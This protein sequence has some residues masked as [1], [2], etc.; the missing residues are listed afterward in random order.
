MAQN[1]MDQIVR[2]TPV[3]PQKESSVN[4]GKRKWDENKGK[5]SNQHPSKRQETPRNNND[6]S[7][8]NPNYRGKQPHCKRCGK[9]HQGYC[10]V[11]CDK[12]KKTGHMVKDYRVKLPGAP[13]SCY[14]CGQTGHFKNNC[15]NKKNDGPA[16]GRTFNINTREAHEDPD[17]VTGMSLLNNHFVSVLFDTG[18]D[19]SFISKEFRHD[20]SK[21]L[22]PL[23]LK[24]TVE[25]D[26]GKLLKSDKIYQNCTLN[27]AGKDFEIDLIPIE[28][29]SFDMVVGMDWLSKN[30]A[31]VICAKKII[32]IP[33]ENGEPLLVYRVKRNTK[34]NLISC[35]KVQKCL[36]KGCHAILAHVKDVESK[37]KRPN[38][39]PVVKDFIEVFPEKL[40]GLSPH[41]VVEF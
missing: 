13:G 19:K 36:R 34:L 27:L 8:A 39:V 40:P 37:E 30:K 24:Y 18:T 17:L 10:T 23:E 21:P 38:D 32:R 25:L 29:V 11:V 6:G 3:K 12:C 1:L 7:N 31:E 28:L 20:I 15:P 2:R 26:N 14:E 35:L 4:D 22:M 5:N 16:R 33:L 41:R 9:H